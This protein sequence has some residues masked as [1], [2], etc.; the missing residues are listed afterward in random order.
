MNVLP[1]TLVWAY[2]V[3]YFINVP[4]YTVISPPLLFRILEYLFQ[5]VQQKSPTKLNLGAIC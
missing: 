4:L 2:T 5:G 1:Y 3:R